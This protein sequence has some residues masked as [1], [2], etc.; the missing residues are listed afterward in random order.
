MKAPPI[1]DHYV[2][3]EV[4]EIAWWRLARK[5]VRIVEYLPYEAGNAERTS[6]SYVVEVL[7]PWPGCRETTT[8]PH[9]SLDKLA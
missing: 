6:D 9:T 2:R 5:Q 1:T 8:L 4:G 3:F 7:S